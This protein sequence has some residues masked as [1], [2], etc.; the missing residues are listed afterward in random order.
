MRS[1][2]LPVSRPTSCAFAGP[3]LD[4][5]FVTSARIGHEDEELAGG[6]FEVEPGA[7]GLPPGRFAG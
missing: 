4:R 7:A 6:L 5:L 2:A 3:G 1:I